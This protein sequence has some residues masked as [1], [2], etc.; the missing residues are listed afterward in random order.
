MILVTAATGK[1]GRH[2]IAA[3]LAT[4][5]AVRALAHSEKGGMLETM[6]V[7]EILA[8]DLLDPPSLAHAMKGVSAVVHTGPPMHPKETRMGENAIDA[9]R[10]AGVARFVYCSVAHPQIE[11]LLNHKAKLAVE[12]YLIDS[13]LDYTILQPMHYMQNVAVRDVVQKGFLA[14][15]Y[16]LDVKMSFVDLVDVGAAAAKVL[17]ENGHLRATY[18]LCGPDYLSY[19]EVAGAIARESGRN[20]EARQVPLHAA[21]ERNPVVAASGDYGLLAF[22]RMFQYYDRY[23]LSGNPNVLQWLLGRAPGTYAG[24]IGREISSPA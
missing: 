24:Y 2:V 9:A 17:S 3:L 14:I 22:E 1:T 7:R 6:G 13:R 16:S 23:G 21:L 20:V 8:G 18:E 10:A 15:P 5:H 4:G 12:R 19:R 11:A